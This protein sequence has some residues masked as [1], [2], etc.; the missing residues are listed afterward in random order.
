[1]AGKPKKKPRPASATIRDLIKLA[2]PRKQ[3]K[4]VIIHY[5]IDDGVARELAE[6]LIES[7]KTVD[8]DNR[9]SARRDRS[10]VPGQQDHVHVL[11]KGKQMCVINLDGTP[12]HN[13]DISQIPNYLRPELKKMG[14]KIEES[15]FIVEASDFAALAE[16]L[17][18][19]I[20]HI[21]AG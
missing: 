4:T 6:Y 18:A 13:S 12:S 1:L 14:V 8:F 19:N 9:Y 15:H 16:I 21:E 17:R 5:L 3:R 10:H 20:R 2:K 11:L 7:G